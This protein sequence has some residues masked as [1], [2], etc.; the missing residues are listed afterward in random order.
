MA[1]SELYIGLMS[2]TSM[3]AVDGVLLAVDDD[4]YTFNVLA[5]KSTPIDP[6]L[7][8]QLQLLSFPGQDHIQRLGE[9]DI[10][11]G[12]IFAQTVT[13][14]LVEQRLKPADITAIGSHGQTIRHCP[15]SLLTR[16]AYTVQIGDPNTIAVETGITTVADFRRKD[17]ALG[18]EA[19]PLVPGFHQAVFQSPTLNRAVVNIGGI[20]NITWLPAS[21]SQEPVKGFDSGP[22]NCLMD[23]WIARYHNKSFD[24]EGTWASS[25][26][27]S[28][29]M[30]EL[31][32]TEPY[33]AANP[34]KS[35]GKELFNLYWLDRLL[36]TRRSIDP[37]ETVQATLCEF[38][39]SS[40]ASG[41]NLVAG[42]DGIDEVY[43]C[44]GGVLNEH[45][46]ARLR[47]HIPQVPIHSSAYA[48][49]HPLHVEA[50]AFA[51][52]ARQTIKHL[53]GNLPAV[54]GARR[55]TILGGIYLP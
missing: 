30:L 25:G 39:A 53:P 7:K 6:Y 21:N 32:L 49:I 2:G 36:E 45:L 10:A 55:A 9:T 22:G 13:D 34:P 17:M 8:E 44:G 35:T 27:A 14:L 20:A 48:G 1:A 50:A 15:P 3:D 16:Q 46:M 18:G 19:A 4:E 40:I 29:D 33:L 38:T 23:A 11:V 42:D 24:N 47:Q 12:R 31:L 26:T 37:P 54:T 43:V 51:W 28:S 41:L 5:H 52:L